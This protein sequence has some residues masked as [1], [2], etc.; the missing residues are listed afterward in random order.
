MSVSLNIHLSLIT[1]EIYIRG[2]AGEDTD[3]LG[4]I[5]RI[6]GKR[7]YGFSY[8]KICCFKYCYSKSS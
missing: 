8:R 5:L 1:C 4:Q 7:S 6:L 3:A 2:L